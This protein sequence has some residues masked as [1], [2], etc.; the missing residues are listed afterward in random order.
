[1]PLRF[2]YIFYSYLS[3]FTVCELFNFGDPAPSSNLFSRYL[4][5]PVGIVLVLLPCVL[6]YRCESH[7]LVAILLLRKLI[8]S[9]CVVCAVQSPIYVAGFMVM[10]NMCTLVILPAQKPVEWN[11]ELIV[12][13]VGEALQILIVCLIVGMGFA[14]EGRATEGKMAV[15]T[16]IVGLVVVTVLLYIFVTVAALVL[17]VLKLR[18]RDYVAEWMKRQ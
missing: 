10:V 14:G 5:P 11:V 15:G 1:M 7:R 18:G 9:I 8:L 12:Y 4:S 2:L 6:L 3:L 16:L 17:Y 13:N